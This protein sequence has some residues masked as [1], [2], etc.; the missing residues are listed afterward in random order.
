MNIRR[1]VFLLLILAAALAAPRPLRAEREPFLV[2]TAWLAE[3]L[4]D[5]NLVLIQVGVPEEFNAAHI[6]GA[7]F[8]S[9]M[10]I[11]T[12][13]GEGLTLQV[14]PVE[15]LRD[16]FEKLGVSDDSRI[17]VYFG[18]DWVTPTA[19]VFLTLEYLGLGARTSLLDGGLPTWQAEGRPVSAEA[20]T[21]ARGKLT[22]RPRSDVI[23]TAEWVNEHRSDPTAAI[24]DA[25]HAQFYSG[26]AGHMPRGG[27]IPGARSI[28]YPSLVEESN[29]LKDRAALEEI[30]RAAGV[31]PGQLVV[32]YCHIGQ[33]ASLAWFVARM[34]GY[35]AR[36][37][38]GSFEEWSARTEFPV[39]GPAPATPESKP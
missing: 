35:D 4:R 1:A 22:P 20:T 7:V 9:Y 2:S 6:P 36:L 25:R 24:V 31:R 27:H 11:S 19:R 10:D 26:E 16:T 29:K 5:K 33:Q 12:P 30:F 32:T 21:P 15:Q 18:K 37:Y 28:P 8:L 38:D 39:V 3:H 17:V 34:L 13:R 23:V 14:P